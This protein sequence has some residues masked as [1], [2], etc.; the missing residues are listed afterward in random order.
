MDFLEK[1]SSKYFEQIEDTNKLQNDFEI[2]QSEYEREQQIRQ[3]FEKQ[4]NEA[5]KLIEM[6]EISIFAKFSYLI[7]L[8]LGSYKTFTKI[9]KLCCIS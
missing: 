4:F 7:N 8:L 9:K 2:L 5:N 1:F 6:V 3:Q